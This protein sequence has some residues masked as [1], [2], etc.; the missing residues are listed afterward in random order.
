MI[1]TQENGKK[2]H[3]GPHS[4][5]LGLNMGCQFFKKICLC[6]SLDIT[7]SYHYVQYQKKLMIQRQTDGQTDGWMDRQ[8]DKQ[9]DGQTDKSDSTGR[10]L[11]NVE[12]PVGN[13][14]K[15]TNLQILN[16]LKRPMIMVYFLMSFKN[17][18]LLDIELMVQI[19]MIED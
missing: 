9:T 8:M 16:T 13:S 18:T 19:T 6:Q 7:I 5:P 3:S 17:N 14:S 12:H 10:C 2:P 11:I 4:S 15:I 1:Q